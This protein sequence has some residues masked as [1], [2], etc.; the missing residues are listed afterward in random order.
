MIVDPD[1]VDHWKT[2]LLVNS[3]TDESAPIYVLRLW[4]HCQNRKQSQFTLTPEA[5]KALCRFSGPADKLESSLVASG[6]I[7]RDETEI[8]VVGWE[9]Y[10]A[11]LIANW[12]NGKKGGRPKKPPETK[13]KQ[14]PSKTHGLPMANPSLTHGEPIRVDKS[15]EDKN[16][17]NTNTDLIVED[18]FE[19]F[20]KSFPSGRKTAKAKAKAAFKR[21]VKKTDPEVIIAAAAEYAASDVGK[22]QYVKG[23]EPWLNGGCWD[24]DRRAWNQGSGSPTTGS[25]AQKTLKAAERARERLLDFE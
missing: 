11:G 3:L 1:F 12:E 23:P 16:E 22:G 25:A 19:R 4:A 9:E 8:E 20:W 17:L 14:N 10:N 6:F 15:R 7:R 5:L 24:D 13:P 21:C 2:R 18:P